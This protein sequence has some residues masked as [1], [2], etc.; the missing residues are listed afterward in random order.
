MLYQAELRP[1][2]A[3]CLTGVD[4]LVKAICETLATR[5]KDW[6]SHLIARLNS[7]ACC[8]TPGDL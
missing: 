1:D 2:T 3:H 5:S 6:M 8:A 4:G 7:E